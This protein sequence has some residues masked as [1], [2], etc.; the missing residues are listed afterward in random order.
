MYLHDLSAVC[1]FV[2]FLIDRDSDEVFAFASLQS[3]VGLAYLRKA[4]LPLDV[5]TVVLIDDAGVHTR[6]TAALRALMRCG[7]AYAALHA[8][9]IWLPR[10]LRDLG[11]RIVAA[12][13]YRLFGKD[14]GETCRR[15][16]RDMSR[17][18]T[19][20]MPS[21]AGGRRG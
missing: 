14:E 10:P 1:T 11:Y 15:M 21:E 12:L 18:F 13:R 20:E 7:R 9:L 2:H 8:A 17:R 4:G 5:S 6:S 3:D 16:T 19:V